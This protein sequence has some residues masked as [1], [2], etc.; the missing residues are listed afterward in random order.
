MS[1]KKYASPLVLEPDPSRIYLAL[2][3]F[4]HLG[5]MA[6]VIPLNLYW[7]IK[8]VLWTVL[9]VSLV[10]VVR[11]QGMGDMQ[12]LTWKEGNDW[13]MHLKDGTK[14]EA[15]LLPSTYVSPWLVVLNFRKIEDRGNRSVTLFRDALE[16]ELFR[17]LRVRL[18]L[19]KVG[20]EEM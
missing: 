15:Q 13:L 2:M 10:F 6:V 18:A 3:L 20:D 4:M 8:I 14:I 1:S 5:A 11:K 12:S 7:M 16:K 19:E 9:L 17:K